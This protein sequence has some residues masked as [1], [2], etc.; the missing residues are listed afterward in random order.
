MTKSGLG[1]A[2]F[3]RPLHEMRSASRDAHLLFI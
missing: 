2:I 3:D 1:H